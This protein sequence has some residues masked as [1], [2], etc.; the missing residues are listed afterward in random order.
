MVG[1]RMTTAS[2]A[3]EGRVGEDWH[4]GLEGAWG[5]SDAVRRQ[6]AYRFADAT[7]DF[8]VDG[9]DRRLEWEERSVTAYV[10][11]L[12]GQGWSVL[13]RYRLASL[14]YD[15]AWEGLGDAPVLAIPGWES[16][17]QTR[18]LVQRVNLGLRY[19]AP[20]GWYAGADA[21]W[22]REWGSGARSAGLV[23]NVRLDLLAGYRFA[24]RRAE[25]EV[26]IENLLDDDPRPSPLSVSGL[27]SRERAWVV[28]A[29]W[30]Y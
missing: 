11:W 21:M 16:T 9:L 10:G 3:V 26:G 7:G 24:R 20:S 29:R 8:E 23:D 28:R 5:G 14:A 12:A 4:L 17:S 15:E 30:S 1:E 25:V 18:L 22:W 6:G 19:H 27:V 2:V 13:G